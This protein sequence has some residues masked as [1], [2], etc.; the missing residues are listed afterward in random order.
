[1]ENKAVE[2]YLVLLRRELVCSGV[3]RA[4]FLTQG[5]TL[6]G[7]FLE[8]NPNA[9]YEDLAAAY[10]PPG[11]LAAE[12]LSRLDPGEVERAGRQRKYIRRALAAVIALALIS[13]TVYWAVKWAKAQEV[14]RG[15]FYVV[16]TVNVLTEEEAYEREQQMIKENQAQKGE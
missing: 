13:C 6:L 2:R 4:R 15:D 11:D 12:M 10:G 1:M 3:D 16:E 7:E 14:L 5:R 9:R 8:E